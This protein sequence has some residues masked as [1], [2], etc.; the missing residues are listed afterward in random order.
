MPSLKD[1]LQRTMLFTAASDGGVDAYVDLKHGPSDPV[2][3]PVPSL[4]AG[5]PANE[6]AVW[7]WKHDPGAPATITNL[8]AIV[9]AAGMA[10]AVCTKIEVE[11]V[12]VTLNPGDSPVQLPLTPAYVMAKYA[13]GSAHMN[14]RS[15]GWWQLEANLDCSILVVFGYELV[16]ASGAPK[17]LKLAQVESLGDKFF[18]APD[19]PADDPDAGG[20]ACVP[21]ASVEVGQ[22]VTAHVAPPWVVVAFGFTTCKER[23]DFEPGAILG[24]GRIYP[25]VM[26]ACNRPMQRAEAKIHIVRPA[27]VMTH[28]PESLPDVGAIFI[29]DTNETHALL[30]QVGV[31]FKWGS[32]RAPPLPLWSNFFDYYDLSPPTGTEFQF[33]DPSKVGERVVSKGIRRESPFRV[34][35]PYEASSSFKKL[36]G[37]GAF[38]NVHLAPPMQ[39]SN[40]TGTT[41]PPVVMAP[42][43]EHD[44]LHTHTRWGLPIPLVPRSNLGFA[45]RQPYAAKGAPLVPAGQSVFITRTS[46]SSFRYRAQADP[47]AAG[48][49]TVFNHHGSAYSLSIAAPTEFGKAR[50]GVA[51]TVIQLVEPYTRG[52]DVLL[53]FLDREIVDVDPMSSLAA[54]YQRLQFTGTAS[55]DVFLPRIQILDLD[56]CR[57]T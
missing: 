45:G 21:E 5:T 56:L 33:V 47:I 41:L 18:P 39:F 46:A 37:Q 43:C 40:P 51:A 29:A 54:F 4:A 20:E 2:T 49:W 8:N 19:V 15:S 44:C 48:A 11:S 31:D 23:A 9:Q 55:P 6:R 13:L 7:S 50:F 36:P 57:R 16:P 27:T 12:S 14:S 17:A 42:F 34:T 28:S 38:D 25:H 10:M 52:L 53:P 24:A 26:V 30:S 22:C 35:D 32:L 1:L 3:F